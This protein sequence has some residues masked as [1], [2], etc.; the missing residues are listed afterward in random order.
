MRVPSPALAGV[1]FTLALLVAPLPAFA[2]STCAVKA[3]ADAA[4]QRQITLID[5]AKVNPSDFFDGA[6]SCIATNLLQQFDLSN[7][8][9]DLSGFLTSAAQNL[10][11]QALNTAKQQVCS[12]LNSQLQSAIN[13]INAKLYAFRS[14]LS[15][16]L[17]KLLNGNTNAIT[18]PNVTGIGSYTFNA[19]SS[20]LGSILG[21]TGGAAT[22][23]TTT[24]SSGAPSSSSTVDY[25]SILGN[26]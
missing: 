13:Q 23:T 25:S 14:T 22:P 9:P 1:A 26:N 18:L 15:A 5:A 19:A 2:G 10:V 4:V 6:N 21:T 7:L 12:I 17:S 24:T 20:S 16:D 11:T 8:I 3:A